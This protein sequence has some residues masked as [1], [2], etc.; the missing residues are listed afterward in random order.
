[1]KALYKE[2][3]LPGPSGTGMREIRKKNSSPGYVEDRHVGE[4]GRAK[5][6]S[7]TLELTLLPY[8]ASTMRVP[9]FY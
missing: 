2:E 6:V 1:M 9:G 4:M 5:A 7:P 8:S 3:E